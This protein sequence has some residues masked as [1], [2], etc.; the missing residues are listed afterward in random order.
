MFAFEQWHLFIT[1]M[2]L[3][4][5]HQVDLVVIY[6]Q[7]VDSQVRSEAWNVQILKKIQDQKALENIEYPQKMKF[8]NYSQ[9]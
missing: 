8:N 6:V 3:H 1:A 5:I 9:I 7:S 4:R 2:E